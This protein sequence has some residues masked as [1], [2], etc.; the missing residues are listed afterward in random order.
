MA[1]AASA[2][3]RPS[4]ERMR[5]APAWMLMPTPSGLSS[6][7]A[8]KTSTSKPARW[9]HIAAVKPPMPAPAM[10]IFMMVLGVSAQPAIEQGG[11]VGGP[12]F[13]VVVDRL[14]GGDL[15][16]AAAGH[17]LLLAGSVALHLGRRALDAQVLGRQRMGDAVGELDLH[18]A[19]F[20]ED[21]QLGRP[22]RGGLVAAFVGRRFGE[23]P[24]LRVV[25]S[26]HGTSLIWRA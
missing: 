7:T 15:H 14:D 19:L 21:A 11:L 6:L 1:V 13:G 20:L 26:A 16:M 22:R 25:F 2:G 3:C 8:S 24:L 10:A 4:P 23:L 9:R 5:T 18:P 12:F 17:D